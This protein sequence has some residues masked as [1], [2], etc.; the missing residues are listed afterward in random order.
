MPYGALRK[1]QTG[2]VSE[3]ECK[4]RRVSAGISL[5]YPHVEEKTG[6]EL[7]RL[8]SNRDERV[9]NGQSLLLQLPIDALLLYTRG[10]S[11]FEGTP[12][13]SVQGWMSNYSETNCG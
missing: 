13:H 6:L 9:C 1:V 4:L 11:R 12:Y 8:A 10:A 3:L 5:L 7:T 2:F